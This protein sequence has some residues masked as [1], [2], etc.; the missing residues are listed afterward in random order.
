MMPADMVSYGDDSSASDKRRG[1]VSK[2]LTFVL[3]GEEYGL[4][5]IRV[6]EIIGLMT[7]TH[8]PR[9]PEF[10]R[11]VINLRG[12]VIPVVDL[13]LKFGMEKTDGQTCIVVV[14]L[15][16]V[17]MGVVVDRVSEVLDIAEGDVE[18]APS[19]GVDVDTSFI[20]GIG[21]TKGRVVILLDIQKVLSPEDIVLAARAS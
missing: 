13:R 14:D 11:G 10:V 3:C 1:R 5:I 21:K 6:R 17:L 18:P 16:D 15:D 4:E 20:L 9:M 8:V 12:K 2:Y 19:F 7:I